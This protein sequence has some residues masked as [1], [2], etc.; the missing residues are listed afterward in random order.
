MS[1]KA[2]NDNDDSLSDSESYLNINIPQC[3]SRPKSPTTIRKDLIKCSLT[4]KSC[5]PVEINRQPTLVLGTGHF[6]GHE[7]LI[8]RKL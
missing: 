7:D 1:D 4:Y 5:L 3:Y 8:W 6:L 2:T